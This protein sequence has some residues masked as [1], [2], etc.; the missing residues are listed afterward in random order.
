MPPLSAS[1]DIKKPALLS[2]AIASGVAVANI[3]Y[4]QPMLGII[5]REFPH[6]SLI[7]LTPTLTQL[8]YAA[9]LFFLL[10]L[11]DKFDR[12][13][14]IMYQL[15]VL[16]A[17][18]AIA[19]ISPSPVILLLA[20]FAIGAA[21]TVAQQIVPL[22]ALLSP[23]HK[24]GA[25]IGTVMAGVL[26]G[27]L[28]SRTVA[29]LVSQHLGWRPMF[30]LAIPIILLAG[31]RMAFVLPARPVSN[32]ASY[33]SLIASL[34]ALWQRHPSLRGAAIV[35]AL[36]FASFSTFWTVLAFYLASPRFGMGADVAGLFGIVGAVGILAAPL[37]GRLTDKVGPTRIV[38]IGG[39][40][41]LLSWIVLGFWPG[42]TGLIVGVILLD[43][44]VQVSLIA[45]QHII[46]SLDH[47]AKGRLNAIFMTAMFL[48][49]A[50]G[51]AIAVIE[52]T[53]GGW[54]TVSIVGA[55]LPL[56]AFAAGEMRRRR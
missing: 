47:A 24:Q 9:G 12:K 34:L 21:S 22:A 28:L 38:T 54:A 8:G 36:L 2:M 13:R 6:S 32:P 35:Q 45:N 49:G 18:L 42:L 4:S 43:L 5:E 40:I 31:L 55:L 11:G 33:R 53:L 27:I 39:G 15:L 3:Y 25:A 37:A 29:G 19:A 41:A 46:Y 44:G 1:Q 50:I 16:C 30:W 20:S 10:P 48:G 17:A 14:I 7:A 52:W 26:S 23:P 56:G 51:S